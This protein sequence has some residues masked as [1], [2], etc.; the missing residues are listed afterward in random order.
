MVR[1]AGKKPFT[2]TAVS[3]VVDRTGGGTVRRRQETAFAQDPS[4]KETFRF[5][6]AGKTAFMPEEEQAELDGRMMGNAGAAVSDY[7]SGHTK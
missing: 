2:F 5:R 7:L 4:P 6:Q 3:Y 1:L